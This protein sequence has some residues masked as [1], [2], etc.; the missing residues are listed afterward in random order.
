M[1]IAHRQGAG[2]NKSLTPMVGGWDRGQKKDRGQIFFVFFKLVFLNSPHRE[3][4]RLVIKK[5]T[6]VS[7]GVLV[8]FFVNNFRHDI[9]VK[10]CLGRF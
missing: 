6:K 8:D 1:P 5:L 10:R 2:Q 7:F 3:T 4:A 9:F